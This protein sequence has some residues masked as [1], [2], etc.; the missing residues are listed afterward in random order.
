MYHYYTFGCYY[1]YYFML[2]DI[3][4]SYHSMYN[5]ILASSY[6]IHEMIVNTP[7][8]VPKYMAHYFLLVSE[9]RL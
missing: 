9:A 2:G 5:F 7:G 4:I 6:P 1:C 8:F 3:A